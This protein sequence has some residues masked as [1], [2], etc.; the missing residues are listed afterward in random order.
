M[1]YP[2][3]ST[4]ARAHNMPPQ[5]PRA[6]L[7][8]PKKSFERA[9]RLCKGAAHTPQAVLPCA[10]RCAACALEHRSCAAQS[11]LTTLCARLL[12][13]AGLP[14]RVVRTVC[15]A[16]ALAPAEGAATA[17]RALDA[18]EDVDG[19]ETSTLSGRGGRGAAPS[20][21]DGA[22]TPAAAPGA[23]AP[24]APAAAAAGGC[25]AAPT[26]APPGR[27]KDII[28]SEPSNSVARLRAQSPPRAYV[29]HTR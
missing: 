20:A 12:R 24:A 25:G 16:A 19:A 6:R 13:R 28:V 26:P 9:W 4:H 7:Q 2:A 18:D 14:G 11:P 8:G 23:A 21:A 3:T 22:P 1:R 5:A 17:A 15:L 27:R 10:V 29:T